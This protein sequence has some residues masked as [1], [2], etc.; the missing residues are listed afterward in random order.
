[1]GKIIAVS[2]HRPGKLGGYGADVLQRATRL[3]TK[4]LRAL[5]PKQVITGMAL[6]WD[7]ACALAAIKLQIPFIAA[8]PFKGQDARWTRE[9]RAMYRLILDHSDEIVMVSRLN[10]VE[11]FQTRNVWMADHCEEVLALWD[12]SPGGTAHMIRYATGP[13]RWRKIYNAWEEWE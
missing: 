7:T 8:L 4:Y 5:E 3:A 9:Q 12:G 10:T 2:G 11:A 13:G 6:G 1:M